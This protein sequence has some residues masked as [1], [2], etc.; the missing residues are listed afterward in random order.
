MKWSKCLY[1]YDGVELWLPI[2]S[3]TISVCFGETPGGLSRNRR[4][5]RIPGWKTLHYC[6]SWHVTTAICH[7][8][9]RCSGSNMQLRLHRFYFARGAVMRAACQADYALVHVFKHHGILCD[10]SSLFTAAKFHTGIACAT[11][12]VFSVFW[13]ARQQVCLYFVL[14]HYAGILAGEWQQ[15]GRP[16]I[17]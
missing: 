1:C 2:S 13:P 11:S 7:I 15:C 4:V 5:P 3:Q 14:S 8:L 16:W 10:W 12:R 6:V 17:F 9:R